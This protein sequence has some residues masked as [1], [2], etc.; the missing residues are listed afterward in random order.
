MNAKLNRRTSS[1]EVV[2]DL[3]QLKLCVDIS[4]VELISFWETWHERC[5]DAIASDCPQCVVDVGAN[6]GAFSLYQAMAKNAKRVIAFEPSPLVFP[7]LVKNVEMNGRRN[8]RVVNAAV[9]SKPGVLSFSEGRMSINSR[10]S[11]SGPLKV[12]CVTLD[13]ELFDIPS[14][15]ILKVDTEGYEMH[16]LRGASE[17]LQKT[18]RIALE[19]HYSGE[20][21]EIES[22][23]LPLGFSLITAHD[24]L[25]FYGRIN[26]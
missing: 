1:R 4:R 3:R 16:V 25:V 24:K 10:I 20:R 21:E 17:T 7:R 11:E 22:I 23:L 12:S 19:L 13:E 6:I 26:S 9:G 14:I 15:D 18:R 2:L 8:V 5:Y